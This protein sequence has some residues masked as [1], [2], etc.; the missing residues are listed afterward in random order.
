MAKVFL[1]WKYLI[2]VIFNC[3]CEREGKRMLERQ[4]RVAGSVGSRSVCYMPQ[5]VA[6]AAATWSNQRGPIADSDTC[7]AI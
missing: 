5:I 4:R 3:V 2:N 7:T 1:L 6:G